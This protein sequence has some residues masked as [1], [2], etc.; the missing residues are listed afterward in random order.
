MFNKKVLA[1]ALAVAFSHSAIAVD[2]DAD[3]GT[4][5]IANEG[6]PADYEGLGVNVGSAGLDG[7]LDIDFKAGFSITAGTSK[8][9]RIDLAGGTFGPSNT[10]ALTSTNTASAVVSTGGLDGETS[11]VIEVT[12]NGTGIDQIEVLTVAATD[13]NL[14]TSGNTTV[15]YRLYDNASDAVTGDDADALATSSGVLATYAS[16]A[17]G[18]LMVDP[19]DITATIASE[20]SRFDYDAGT[21]ANTPNMAS[22]SLGQLGAVNPSSYVST[23]PQT[24]SVNLTGDYTALSNA[25]DLLG[26]TAVLNIEGI[27]PTANPDASQAEFTLNS[28]A[29]CAVGTTL[30]PIVDADQDGVSDDIA[31]AAAAYGVTHY[32]CVDAADVDPNDDESVA[33]STYKATLTGVSGAVVMGD[34]GAIVY[35]TT[36]VSVPYLTTYSEYNQRVYL[37]N[38]SNAEVAYST[39]FQ[40]EAGV[41]ATP[42]T[43]SA[44]TIP[45]NT[46]LSLKA[47]DMVEL[48]GKTRTAAVIELEAVSESVR[49]VTQNINLSDGTTDT[50]VLHDGVN[51]ALLP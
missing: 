28:A 44:G 11:V 19:M 26:A 38:D 9:V 47:S 13:F 50:T 15:V 45:A 39:S 14:N 46:V 37:I 36:S 43:A 49:V 32:L 4:L 16:A 5:V 7:L 20:F 41:T 42:K 48:T 34:F 25:S 40:S 33:K 35:D 51:N 29:D 10:V 8:Y 21:P 3:T 31:V 24:Y 6:I 1:A 27:F 22:D 18:D 23:S 30:G 17:S 12:A 2:L